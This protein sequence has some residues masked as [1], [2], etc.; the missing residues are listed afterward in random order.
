MSERL[1]ESDYL[2]VGAGACAMAFVDELLS[3]SDSTIVMVDRRDNPGGHWND[4]YPFVRLHQP[5]EFYGVNSRELGQRTK[6]VSGV[7]KGLY[8]LASGSEVLAYFD[9]V[10][11]QRFLPSGRVQY[12][13]MCNVTGENRFVSSLT[14][15]DHEVVAKRAVVDAAYCTFEIPSTH[16][17]KYTVAPGVR[18]IPPNQLPHAAKSGDNY[19]IVGAG[20]TAMDVCL[21]LLDR[22]TNPDHIRWIIPRDAWFLNRA[23]VQ[24]GDEF[25]LQ[26]FGSQA[27]QLEAVGAAKSVSDLFERL[28]AND[29][30][31]RLD[32]SVRPT[33][34]HCA[35]MSKDELVELRRIK[36]LIRLGYVQAIHRDEISLDRGQLPL[37]SG[38]LI[39]NCSASGLSRKPLI[40]IWADKRINI[41][42]IRT[43]QPLFSAA[44]VGFVEATFQDNQALKNSLCTPVPFPV[45][46]TD[47]LTM[48]AVSMKNR[49]AWRQYPQI[50]NWLAQS[51]LN[52]FFALAAQVK[53]EETEKMAVLKM[54]QEA[55]G[56]AA[57]RLPQLLSSLG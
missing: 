2:V 24:P 40:P 47:W 11:Q 55:A 23:N 43:C 20:K 49:I 9:R 54:F 4:A 34:Y 14:G 16:P 6:Y 13:P 30:I 32:P 12:F 57:S 31:L 25:F 41:Q 3:H 37:T 53:P 28:E 36:N 19:V 33:A 21:W 15:N 44:L 42:L 45:S 8:N 50:E 52:G 7:N 10:M 22:G 27:R 1:I 46:D 51:R 48:L 26:S 18:C 29:E 39:I 17:P 5:S 35:V 38:D 56:A